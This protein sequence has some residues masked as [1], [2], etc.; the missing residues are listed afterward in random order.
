M[1]LIIVISF[2]AMGAMQ[3]LFSTRYWVDEKRNL[4][5]ENTLRIAEMTSQLAVEDTE[6]AGHYQI[7]GDRLSPYLSLM[8]DAIDATVLV[9]SNKG[10]VILCS[11]T[12]LHPS[13]AMLTD[14]I[15]AKMDGSGFF[16]V[17]KLGG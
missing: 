9:V 12:A 4:L 3:M 17:G 6:N 11:D 7:P 2:A 8:A 5:E 1:S 15:V 13:D 10:E 16:E 14:A